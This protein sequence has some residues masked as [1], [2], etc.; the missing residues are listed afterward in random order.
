MIT[1]EEY[2]HALQI[3]KAYNLQQIIDKENIE[4]GNFRLTDILP[5]RP[6]N[7]IRQYN[8]CPIYGGFE[9]IYILDVVKLIKFTGDVERLLRLRG[10]GRL[11]YDIIMSHVK[12]YLEV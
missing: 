3:V 8:T 9:L 12:P 6:R 1:L 4:S 2:Q 7:V 11:S 10:L 5:T